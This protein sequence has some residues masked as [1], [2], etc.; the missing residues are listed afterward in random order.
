MLGKALIP[1]LPSPSL[2]G[3]DSATK[4]QEGIR[5]CGRVVYLGSGSVGFSWR[6]LSGLGIGW[7]DQWHLLSH[8]VAPVLWGQ[9]ADDASEADDTQTPK[10][11]YPHTHTHMHAHAHAH[12]YVHRQ[13]CIYISKHTH[14]HIDCS[15]SSLPSLSRGGG[16]QI[17][18]SPKIIYK[19]LI[20]C[21]KVNLGKSGCIM[22]GA[23]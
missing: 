19:V 2:Q 17:D 16:Q 9:M 21:Q 14:M 11:V 23:G 22:I 10:R 5:L 20:E 13:T 3:T 1:R 15:Q 18:L 8:H 12:T 6:H 4:G 7:P